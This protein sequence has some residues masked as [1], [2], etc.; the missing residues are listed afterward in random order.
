MEKTVEIPDGVKV[1]FE[2]N[3]LV[4]SGPEGEIRKR[5]IKGPLKVSQKK[6]EI[7]F[8]V[9]STRR[10]KISR[11]GTWASHLRN[12]IIGV[13]KG[14]EAKSKLVYSHFP[15]KLKVEGDKVSIQN[16]MGEQRSRES[17]IIGD[18]EVK[19]QKDELTITGI[20][21]EDVGQTAAN[22]EIVTKVKNKDKRVYQ[23]GIYIVQKPKPQE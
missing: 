9:D 11:V 3:V 19:I 15:V 18:T 23:D 1:S 14:W 21:K 6:N 7:T 12:M 13:T 5:F 20:N 4:V 10:K 17:N 2:E 16:F 8:S 22:L